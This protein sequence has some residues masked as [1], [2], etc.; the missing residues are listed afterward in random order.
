MDFFSTRGEGPIKGSQAIINGI[1]KDGGLYV[2]SSFPTISRDDLN[3]MI[4]LDYEERSAYVMSLYLDDFSY[5]ELLEYTRGAYS[6]FD[7]DPAPIVKVDEN[8]YVLELWHGPTL[9]F[10]DMALTVLPYLLTNSK[11]KNGDENK[12]LILVATSGDTGKA[13][14][15]GFKNV[16]NTEIIVFYPNTGVSEMQRLQMQTTTGDNVHVVAI[17]GNFDDAQSA[18][19]TIFNSKEMQDKIK[20][21]G[22]SLSSANSI[23]FGRLLPQICYYVSS[24][25]DLLGGE[26]IKLGDEINF[27][28]PSGNFGNILAGYYAKQMGIPIKQLIVASNKNNVLTEFFNEAKYD[29]NRKFYKTISPSMDILISSNLERLIYEINDRDASRVVELMDELKQKGLYKIDEDVLNENFG[30]FLAYSLE[31]EEIKE[32]IQN[33]FDEY[34]YVLDTH[35]AVGMGVY[36]EY[37]ND[38]ADEETPTVIVSTANPYKFP[39]DVLQAIS[40]KYETDP[41]KSV[42]KL[43]KFSGMEIPTQI[44]ELPT[45]EVIH[46]KVVEKDCIFEAVMEIIK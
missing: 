12:T 19:K 37:L 3:D 18:V 22:Y 8:T 20:E 4:E 46:E 2:P 16:P 42:T 43:E 9:A 6:K 21:C 38:T 33:V 40:G 7:G 27:V 44:E 30:E 17:E 23:N 25:L 28:V 45:L 24:Y 10:K 34:G 15:E 13:A 14:L 5:E 36:F 35:T 41:Q 31:E 11:A 29:I 26:Q 1:A 32:V 39:Q